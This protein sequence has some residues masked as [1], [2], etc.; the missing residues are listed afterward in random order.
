MVLRYTGNVPAMAGCS[1]CQKKFFAL[2][3]YSRDA[4]GAQEYLLG[5]FDMHVCEQNRKKPPT[6]SPV[7][8]TRSK[9]LDD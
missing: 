4:V 8:S 6:Q 1:N 2:A 3:I 7:Y 9:W 5:K